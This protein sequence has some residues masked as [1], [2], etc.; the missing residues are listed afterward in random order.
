[1]LKETVVNVKGTKELYGAELK[2]RNFIIKKIEEVCKKYNFEPLYTPAL[3]YSKLF[4]NAYGEEANKLIFH[5]LNSGDFM[6]EYYQQRNKDEEESSV[7]RQFISEKYLRYDLTLSLMRFVYNNIGKIN[8]PF[9]RYQCQP[10]WRA[11]RPQRWR[12]REFLQFDIDIV[13]EKSWL[14]ENEMLLFITDVFRELS[15]EEYTIHLNHRGVLQD[16]ATLVGCTENKQAMFIILDKKDKIGLQNVLEELHTINISQKGID[17]IRNIFSLECSGEEKLH[18]LREMFVEN[19]IS[20]NNLEEMS[21]FYNV[22]IKNKNKHVDVDF[23]LV[24]GLAYY[25][26]LIYEVVLN[27]SSVGSVCGGGRYGYFADKFEREELES[28]G[29]SFGID[30]L[31]S[32]L[33]ER[34]FNIEEKNITVLYLNKNNTFDF[35][36]IRQL[37]RRV[38]VETY[39]NQQDN[40]SKQLRYG[41]KKNFDF[42][43]ENDEKQTGKIKVKNMSSGEIISLYKNEIVEYIIKTI[44]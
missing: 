18:H 23:S 9:R 8:F 10:V 41:N 1:M 28:V 30:R 37:R 22:H 13:G 12:L 20:L 39:Y 11:D 24:R 38:C 21:S 40:I 32:G 29:L 35:D 16:I 3:E 7:L 42:V 19:N 26:G 44:K 34:N 25:T 5:I 36:F 15:I 6:K 14:C 33:E 43:I 17:I 27:N 4:Q 31:C 2:K